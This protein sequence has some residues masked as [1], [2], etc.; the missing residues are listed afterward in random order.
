MPEE[1]EFELLTVD[2]QP[3]LAIRAVVPNDQLAFDMGEWLP[4]VWKYATDNGIELAG[5]PFTRY[6]A[7]GEHETDLESGLPVTAPRQGEGRIKPVELPGGEVASTWHVGP[8]DRLP[9][10]HRA[11]AEWVAEQGR[12]QAGPHWE[13]YWTDPGAEPDPAKWRTQVLMPLR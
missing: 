5:P 10:T 11:L 1:P 2:P 6:H 4:A 8:Y 7:M 9:E 3:A 12:T 13:V